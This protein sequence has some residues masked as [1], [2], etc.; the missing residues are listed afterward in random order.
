VL[1][2]K[3]LVTNR[4]GSMINN[5][6]SRQDQILTLLLKAPA[7]L[8]IDQ[9]AAELDISR[10]A[11]KQHLL[12][13][14]NQNLVQAAGLNSTGG[15][16]ARSYVLTEQGIH[17]FPKQYAWFCNL[18]LGELA[19]EMS[20]GALEKLFWKMGTEL[21]ASL[22]GQFVNKNLSERQFALV[23]LMQS[24]GYHAELVVQE[25]ES[26]ITA[27]NCVY[28][29]LAFKHPEICQF[30]LALM[31]T[32]LETPIRQKDCMA[33]GSCSCRFNLGFP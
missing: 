10:N 30:D 22:A 18:I 32:L 12:G 11:L 25:G 20:S 9:L 1:S 3:P 7:G 5:T 33:T 6:D 23:E 8:S 26:T 14:E 27:V 19:L 17:R 2:C 29:D 24:L 21:A 28:H 15:R 16:P 13:L 4:L 31:T